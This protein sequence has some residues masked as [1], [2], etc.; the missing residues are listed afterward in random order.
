LFVL[1]VLGFGFF[2]VSFL[3]GFVICCWFLCG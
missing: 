3:S 1:V 2:V